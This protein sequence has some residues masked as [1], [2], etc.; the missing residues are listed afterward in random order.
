MEIHYTDGW[1]RAKKRPGELLADKDAK[2]LYDRRG[3]HAAVIGPLDKPR[4]FIELNNDYVGVSF[5]D[6]RLREYLSYAFQEIEAGKLFLTRATHR[7]FDGDTDRVRKGT[8]YIFKPSGN[9][10]VINEEFPNGGKTQHETTADVAGNWESYPAF[11]AYDSL[12]REE[13]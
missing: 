4:A 6:E 11:G 9:V 8:T 12:V 2:A 1:F 5:L 13:R 3:L 7:Y 10:T